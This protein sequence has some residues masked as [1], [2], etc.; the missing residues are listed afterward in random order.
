MGLRSSDII[1]QI[2][3]LQE[4]LR[5]CRLIFFY[6]EFCY[7]A[8]LGF[9]KIAVLTLF[10]RLFKMTSMRYPILIL[11]ASTVGWLILRVCF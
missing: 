11:L 7:A 8:S 4:V 6:A 10:W 3:P 1:A 2:G 9:A 5:D